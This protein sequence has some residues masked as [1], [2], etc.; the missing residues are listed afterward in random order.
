MDKL[1]VHLREEI[2]RIHL[3]ILYLCF[4]VIQESPAARL[5][6]ATRGN[7]SDLGYQEFL[8]ARLSL[9]KR[10]MGTRQQIRVRAELLERILLQC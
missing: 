4:L 9:K 7:P 5:F 6:Q 3:M 1:P 2:Y 10:R 8:S